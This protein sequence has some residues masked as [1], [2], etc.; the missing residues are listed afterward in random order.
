MGSSD[1]RCIEITNLEQA[2]LLLR[3]KRVEMPTESI[4]G[5]F[6]LVSN[7]SVPPVVDGD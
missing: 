5:L 6:S 4:M 1:S 3:R 2:Q 7:F